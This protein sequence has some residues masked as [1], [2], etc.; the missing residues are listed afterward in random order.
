M[1]T[2]NTPTGQKQDRLRRPN[3][4][5]VLGGV[6]TAVAEQTGT[7]VGLIRLGFLVTALLGGFGI[8]LYCAAWALLPGEFEAESPA[9]HWLHNLTTPGKRL[10]S[11]LIGLAGLVILAGTA[12]A[13]IA[14]AA[15]LLAAAAVLSNDVPPALA[16]RRA[17]PDK[18]E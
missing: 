18:E 12:P 8:V 16:G 6:A 5:R 11:F 7:S 15:A 13:S 4:G 9:E 17:Y 2:E 1:D 10:G 3:E 14:A